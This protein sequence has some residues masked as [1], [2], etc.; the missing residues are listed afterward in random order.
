MLVLIIAMFYNT[1]YFLPTKLKEQ[2]EK[3]ALHF[4]ELHLKM[5]RLEK[6]LEEEKA[7]RNEDL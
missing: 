2:D 1:V 4:K 7:A 5:N 3:F 6:L